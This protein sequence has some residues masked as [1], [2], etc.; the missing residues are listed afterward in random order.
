MITKYCLPHFEPSKEKK[1]RKE[2]KNE[3]EDVRKRRRKKKR[4]RKIRQDGGR[5]IAWISEKSIK[6]KGFDIPIR[7]ALFSEAE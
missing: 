5:E 3:K 6:K 4:R 1:K 2:K 7:D